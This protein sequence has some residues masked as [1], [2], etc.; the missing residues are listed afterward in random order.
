MPGNLSRMDSEEG[1]W[2]QNSPRLS[3]KPALEAVATAKE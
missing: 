2:V 3:S 1:V